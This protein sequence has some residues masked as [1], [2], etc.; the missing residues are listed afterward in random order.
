V[1][2]SGFI[3]LLAFGA[4]LLAGI[5]TVAHVS[6]YRLKQ[7]LQLRR[8]QAASAEPELDLGDVIFGPNE[9]TAPRLTVQATHAESAR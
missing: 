8:Q 5:L 7:R 2:D 1:N 9:I 3:I 4:A 6:A